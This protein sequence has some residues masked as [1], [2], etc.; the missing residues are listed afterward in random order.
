[1]KNLIPVCHRSLFAALLLVAAC[2][3]F[4][5]FA[6][7]RSDGEY[8]QIWRSGALD[9]NHSRWTRSPRDKRALQFDVAGPR[10]L[11]RDHQGALY[12]VGTRTAKTEEEQI[13]NREQIKDFDFD[14]DRGM[15][16][17]SYA[18][19][20]MDNIRIWWK[21][22][23]DPARRLVVSDSHLNEMPRWVD[24]ERFVYVHTRAGKSDFRMGS[25]ADKRR[26]LLIDHTSLNVQDP[27]VHPSGSSA[28]FS[29]RREA[30]TDLWIYTFDTGNAAL[31]Y[32][33]PGLDAEPSWSADGR[34]VLFATWDGSHFRIARIRSDGS[35]MT[36]LTEPGMDC[37]SPVSL[38]AEG[39]D[40]GREN[41]EE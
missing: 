2:P 38:D 5:E 39:G 37:R 4:A 41:Q 28:V 20:A 7:L 27:A 21:A 32:A 11:F 26:D 18:P 15:L 16:L 24:R 31:L 40:P 8:W 1:M 9:K 14:S 17:S 29:G 19:N 30:N 25:I 36:Y 23:G 13:P 10:I 22:P 6:Y 34:W 12:A 35:E 3:G 33:G